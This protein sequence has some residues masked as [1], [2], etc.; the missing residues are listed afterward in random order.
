MSQMTASGQFLDR[1]IHTIGKEH[2]PLFA[3][4]RGIR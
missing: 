3:W 2:K 4:M 1:L